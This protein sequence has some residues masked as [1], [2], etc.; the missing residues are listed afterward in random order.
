MGVSETHAFGGDAI[1][2]GGVDLAAVWI[3]AGDVAITQVVGVYYDDV[4]ERL[5]SE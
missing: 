3:V 5:A 4:G 1:D 2:V